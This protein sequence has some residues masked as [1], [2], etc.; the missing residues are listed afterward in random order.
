[1]GTVENEVALA[2]SWKYI[3]LHYVPFLHAI[4]SSCGNDPLFLPV[5]SIL[6]HITDKD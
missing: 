5:L 3:S 1:V 2:S 4:N 6:F